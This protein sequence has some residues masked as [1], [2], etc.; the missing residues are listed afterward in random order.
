[1]AAGRGS[2]KDR[3]R[4][5]EVLWLLYVRGLHD[6]SHDA[7]MGT[8]LADGVKHRVRVRD[9]HDSLLG[10]CAATLIQFLWQ[11]DTRVVVQ[12]IKKYPLMFGRTR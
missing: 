8:E 3:F 1:M 5:E 10:D 4:A 9:R 11:H 12:F 2:G 7:M 6:V